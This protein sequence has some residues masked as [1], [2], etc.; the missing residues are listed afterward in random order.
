MGRDSTLMPA[1]PPSPC[2]RPEPRGTHT[3]LAAAQETSGGFGALLGAGVPSQQVSAP[4]VL[5]D[6]SISQHPVDV[7][8]PPAVGEV[9]G[10]SWGGGLGASGI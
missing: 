3:G 2:L 7:H 8:C 6:T 9:P 10:L 5:T 1:V 4:T